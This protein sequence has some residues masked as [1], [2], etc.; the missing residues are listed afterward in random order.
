MLP[1]AANRVDPKEA[2]FVSLGLR[3][4]LKKLRIF[5]SL[6]RVLVKDT[7]VTSKEVPGEPCL[8][9]GYG[10]DTPGYRVVVP[11]ESRAD[12]LVDKDVIFRSS[13]HVTRAFIREC[14]AG[15]TIAPWVD[16][17][18]LPDDAL[19][20]SIA[21]DGSPDGYG[22]ASVKTPGCVPAND[23][24]NAV[25]NDTHI[26]P[27]ALHKVDSSANLSCGFTEADMSYL[28][29]KIIKQFENERTGKLKY[30]EGYVTSIDRESNTN[31]IIYGLL[32]NDG[33]KEDV[34]LPELLDLLHN[35][36]SGDNGLA[37][38]RQ[39]VGANPQ[40]QSR[41]ALSDH[42]DQKNSKMLF[43]KSQAKTMISNARRNG[44]SLV[45]SQDNPKLKGTKECWRYDNYKTVTTF[46]QYDELC[47]KKAA[48][49]DTIWN[50]GTSV[51]PCALKSDLVWNVARGYLFFVDGVDSVPAFPAGGAV[52]SN[53][54]IYDE[55]KLRSFAVHSEDENS[56]GVVDSS[57][58]DTVRGMLNSY[59]NSDDVRS[60]KNATKTREYDTSDLELFA[61]AKTWWKGSELCRWENAVR[62]LNIVSDLDTTV[63]DAQTSG[64]QT[65]S[66]PIEMPAWFAL[67]ASHK[68]EVWVEGMK[69]PISLIDAMKS[70]EWPKWKS[71][72]EREIMG[73]LMMDLWD[74][75][76]RSSVPEHQ[77]V[78]SGHFVFKLKCE[79][80][81]LMKC[82]SRY[83]FGGHRS[84]AGID[85]IDTMSHMAA[86]K[87]VRSVLALAA[88]AEHYLRNYD[89]SQAFTFSVCERDVYMELPPLEKMGIYDPRFGRGRGSGYVAKLKRMI[90][91]QRDS[92]RKWMQ[93]LDKFFRKIGAVPTVSDSMV[94]T[95]VFNGYEA[96]FAVHVDDILASAADESVHVE[97][98]RLLRK[99]FGQDRVTECATTW[100][101]GMK[102]D[103]D[104]ENKTITLSQGAYVR[105]LLGAF[106]LDETSKSARTPLPHD[107]VFKK[108]D[109]TAS[110]EDAYQ[111]MVLCGALQWLQVTQV[112][113]IWR[114]L[115]VYCGT[116]PELSI[117]ELH[118]MDLRKCW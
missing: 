26:A 81:K 37:T 84:V 32:F 87:S 36:K 97:F 55:P 13:L 85:F 89:I 35:T 108:F 15:G 112:Q 19:S 40:I 74:E 30:F 57:S 60:L 29:T 51:Q 102:V 105:K 16:E 78:N 118:T 72:I 64:S 3:V 100:I 12:Y 113:N 42:V 109:G 41:M 101:L 10:T 90:Y 65:S 98:S 94:Y 18:F 53:E 67:A 34:Y 82:K 76:P 99:Q 50:T 58:P 116:W 68:A 88:P 20:A 114:M 28:G 111:M 7:L 96:R 27:N 23:T 25:Q 11:R 33:D 52:S 21:L 77:R 79:D 110:P 44:R 73:L 39:T 115:T 9:I 1:T 46:D 56:M 45:F 86:L 107:P 49:V 47:S 4:D 117:W 92:G 6:G 75:V 104:R 61:S 38:L 54:S 69:E 31:K 95:W 103:H 106:G 24:Q 63:H 43:S 66:S 71:S 83:V 17:L 62:K 93:L 8:F 59:L 2:P 22:D 70:P 80:G 5:G 48:F 14:R 91:G